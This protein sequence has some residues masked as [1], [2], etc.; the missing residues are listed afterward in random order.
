MKNEE[1]S[2]VVAQKKEIAEFQR[3]STSVENMIMSAIKEKVDPATMK[4]FLAMRKELKADWAKEQYDKA[5][6]EF[7]AECPIIKR[8]K[9]GSRTK[10]GILAFKYAPLEM[11]IAVVQPLL[12]KNNLSFNFKTVKNDSGKVTDIRCYATHINGHS[13]FSEM[14]VS[15]GGGTQLMSGSQIAAANLTFAKRYAFNNIFGIVTE[16]EDNEKLLQ[17]E[18]VVGQATEDQISDAISKLDKCTTVAGLTTVWFALSK[19]QKANVELIQHANMI[20]SNID[21]ARAKGV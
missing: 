15:E 12:K 13:D 19:E 9:E 11:I 4:E 1:K 17:K 20:R 8:S 18:V 6:S 3:Q 10:S 21:D 7:Q 16:E 5:M 2:V 14:P